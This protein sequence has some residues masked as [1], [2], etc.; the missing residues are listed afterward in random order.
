MNGDRAAH[1]HTQPVRLGSSGACASSICSSSSVIISA[2]VGSTHNHHVESE[3]A[4][5]PAIASDCQL[6]YRC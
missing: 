2:V 4:N 3:R 1:M 6:A 5:A